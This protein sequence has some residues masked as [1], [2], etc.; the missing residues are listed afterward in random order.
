VV[1][2]KLKELLYLCDIKSEIR[3]HALVDF[4]NGWV[5]IKQ[6]HWKMQKAGLK[7]AVEKSKQ[8]E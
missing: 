8:N 5:K 4:Q 3:I 1:F 6:I 7:S 2:D